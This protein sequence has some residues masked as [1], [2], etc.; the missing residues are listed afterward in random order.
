ME[1]RF[2]DILQDALAREG[3]SAAE[4]SREVGLDKAYFVD[5]L[6]GRKKTVS[7]L[8]LMLSA[9]RLGLDPWELA[10]VT[11][12]PD[13][14]DV[15]TAAET[16]LDDVALPQATGRVGGCGIVEEGAFRV[17]GWVDGRSFAAVAGYPVERQS[18]LEVRGHD[19]APWGLPSGTVVHA[20]SFQ[21]YEAVGGP[22]RLVVAT[23]QEG[24][25]TETVLR[26]IEVDPD[27]EMH[28]LTP[29]GIRE[30]PL[31]AGPRIGGLVAQTTLP[32]ILP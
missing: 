20:V 3:I 26:R 6:A 15:R 4:L 2:R 28:L 32:P 10:G 1:D 22:G 30:A 23:R 8:A 5:L 18:V 24:S 13:H 21:R 16:R 12:P 29:T 7:A 9:K 11:R 17:R 27:G 25:L 31:E 14:S 19:Y